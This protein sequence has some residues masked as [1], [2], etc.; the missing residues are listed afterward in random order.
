VAAVVGKVNRQAPILYAERRRSGNRYRRASV[1]RLR[2][3]RPRRLAADA[4]M[5]RPVGKRA[6]WSTA[7]R[8]AG[9]ASRAAPASILVGTTGSG[10]LP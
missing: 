2:L 3:L 9:L 6:A 1:R 5:E 7:G 10:P 8:R 4:E